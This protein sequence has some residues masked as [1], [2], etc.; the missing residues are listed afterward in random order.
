MLL[1]QAVTLIARL[2]L[3]LQKLKV[4]DPRVQ[5]QMLLKAVPHLQASNLTIQVVAL[6]KLLSWKDPLSHVLLKRL[7]SKHKERRL[8]IQLSKVLVPKC[9]E[10]AWKVQWQPQI[11]WL[12]KQHS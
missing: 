1:F 12:N 6:K 9:Q 3:L 8:S 11:I 4:E 5:G 10:S 7:S 2:Q